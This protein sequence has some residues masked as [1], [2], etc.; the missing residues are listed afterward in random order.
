LP[1][2]EA[3]ITFITASGSGRDGVIDTGAV[4][5][6]TNGRTKQRAAVITREFD[7]RIDRSSGETYGTATVRAFLETSD[8]RNEYRLDGVSLGTAPLVV[9]ARAAFGTPRRHRLEI[10]VPADAPEGPIFTSIRWE[11]TTD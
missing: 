4:S 2:D 3:T 7:I 6:G 5:Y 1:A 10:I 9:D 8:S 11:L